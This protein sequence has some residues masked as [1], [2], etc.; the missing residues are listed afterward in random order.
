MFDPTT[1]L[2]PK[3]LL[4][5]VIL[6]IASTSSWSTTLDSWLCRKEIVP[7]FIRVCETQSSP[8]WISV[9]S[10]YIVWRTVNVAQVSDG[11]LHSSK[12]RS[13]KCQCSSFHSDSLTLMVGGV[14]GDIFCG[15]EMLPYILS[16][17]GS[18][19][20][21]HLL[22]SPIAFLSYSICKF[23]LVAISKSLLRQRKA[24]M[25]GELPPFRRLEFKS[26]MSRHKCFA[27]RL[28][29]QLL[30]RKLQLRVLS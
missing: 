13:E 29:F 3:Y 5:M 12:W 18:F 10:S 22:F 16:K 6:E 25:A 15:G 7:S 17:R 23:K 20:E 21:V 30:Y 9:W 19:F 14:F 26:R 27:R 1:K 4:L 2:Q 8:Y 11:F 28:K 24:K